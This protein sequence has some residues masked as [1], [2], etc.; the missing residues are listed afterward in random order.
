V[1]TV[2]YR[3]V[4]ESLT[5]IVRHARADHVEVCV[6]VS[7]GGLR[8][9]VTD[10]GTGFDPVANSGSLGLRGMAERADLAGGR[11]HLRSSP[12]VGTTVQLW[13]PLGDRS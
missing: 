2:A 11:L 5:N 12:G 13:L 3:V 1:E 8:A 9:E 4:Q 10:D 7:N 6:R